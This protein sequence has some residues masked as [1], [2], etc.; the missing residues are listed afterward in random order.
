MESMSSLSTRDVPLTIEILD[1]E[2]NTITAALLLSPF[3][4]KLSAIYLLE[5]LRQ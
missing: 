5:P 3:R 4:L 2:L 1:D